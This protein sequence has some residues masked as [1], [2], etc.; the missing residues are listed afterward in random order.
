[1]RSEKEKERRRESR[2]EGQ[3]REE[4]KKYF[5]IEGMPLEMRKSLLNR[6]TTTTTKT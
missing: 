5:D 1:M 2:K 4:K 6:T 3:Y